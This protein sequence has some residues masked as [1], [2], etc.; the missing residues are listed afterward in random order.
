[1]TKE[2]R[3]KIGKHIQDMC[4]DVLNL[5]H[6]YLS[7]KKAF[8]RCAESIKDGSDFWIDDIGKKAKEMQIAYYR[9]YD[10]K[11]SVS[12]FAHISD[13]KDIWDRIIGNER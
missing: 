7:S 11:F 6:I 12:Q 4:Y 3:I 1:M 13:C 8:L 2:E 9:Y 10:R 5:E